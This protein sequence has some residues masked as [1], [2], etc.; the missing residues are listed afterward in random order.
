MNVNMKTQ[1]VTLALPIELL[2]KVE[3]IAM[4]QDLTLSNF[5]IKVLDDLISQVDVYEQAKQRN[6]EMMSC[7][8]D[9]G[10]N[11]QINWKREE[12]HKR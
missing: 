4:K 8:F 12:L 9:L 11:G 7:G 3:V 6:F 2:H 1:N 10:T 5:L